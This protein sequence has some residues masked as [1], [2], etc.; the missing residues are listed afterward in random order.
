MDTTAR[1][2]SGLT[3][4]GEFPPATEA[5]WRK[6]AEAA[7]KGG[8]FGKLISRTHDGI[9]IQPLYSGP[10]SPTARALRQKPGAWQVAARVD[11]P[12][13]GE[14][15][16]LAVAEL[17]GGASALAL[18]F[19]GSPGACGF[20]L[21]ADTVEA[22]DT[23]LAKV[24]IDLIGIRLDPAGSGLE[25]ARLF[26]GLVARRALVPSTLDL[27]FGCDGTREDAAEL[28]R[29]ARD[30]SDAGYSGTTFTADGRRFHAAGAS[31]AQELAGVL[32]NAVQTLRLLQ[33]HRFT[34][35]GARRNIAVLLAAD[36]DEYLGIA[37]F[38]ALRRLWA[39]V[40]EACG[41]VPRPVRLHAETSW[42]MKTRHDPYVNV[43][44]AGI[45]VFAAA[46]GGADAIVALPF[47]QAL[48]L[49]DA[50]ARR[51]ARNGQ[52]VLLEEAHLA[53]VADPAAGAGGIEALTAELCEKAWAMFRQI[54]KAGGVAASDLPRLIA[55]TAESRA[56]AI[57]TRR[58]ALTG[59]SAFANLA[60][61]LVEVRMP[62]PPGTPPRISA[63]FE[64]LRDRADVL[65]AA[66]KAPR[67]ALACLGDRAA[68]AA[69]QNFA[70]SVFAAG[71]IESVLCAGEDVAARVRASKTALVCIC[72]SDAACESDAAVLAEALRGHVAAIALAGRAGAREAAF[73]AAGI[74]RFIH[75]GGD[76]VAELDHAL[77][78]LETTSAG[79][80]A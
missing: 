16:A 26:A 80:P 37:K 30:L 14:A 17:E 8:G 33:S 58:D 72:G 36:A 51:L 9:A 61:Q 54:E 69:R 71:G 20:G 53:K 76:V 28:A 1:L 38:R 3:S 22:L 60:E 78:V 65:K 42:R 31:E 12:D 77:R 45:G 79:V 19:A 10:V 7:L 29:L 66:G 25:T 32:A 52:L 11:H 2:A 50:F 21:Q 62:L 40:E 6:A 5:Q 70:S 23:A 15:N 35:D 59:T 27:D 39:R 55:A 67:I 74:S 18:V 63:P 68:F 64:A 73:K 44:R 49:P 57:A 13:P 34:M 46:I 75:A 41:L 48:G 47:T 56:S 4:F 24:E 43:L